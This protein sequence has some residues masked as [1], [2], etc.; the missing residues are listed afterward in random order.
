MTLN[1]RHRNVHRPYL[2]LGA[3]VVALMLGFVTGQSNAGTASATGDLNITVRDFPFASAV[4]P[5]TALVGDQIT[6]RIDYSCGSTTVPCED[7]YISTAVPDDQFIFAP[8]QSDSGNSK[9][10]LTLGGT[11][12]DPITGITMRRII[13]QTAPGTLNC[14]NSPGDTCYLDGETSTAT[15]TLTVRND[16]YD[17]RTNY[18]IEFDA[19]SNI[20]TDGDTP[21]TSPP[22]V[23]INETGNIKEPVFDWEVNKSRVLPPTGGSNPDPALGQPTRYRV[24]LCSDSNVDNYNVNNLYFW[25]DVDDNLTAGDF[26]DLDGGTYYDDAA[27]NPLVPGTLAS[28]PVPA[29]NH[30]IWGPFN[31]AFTDG[32]LNRNLTVVYPDAAPFNSGGYVAENTAGFSAD[33]ASAGNCPTGCASSTV[34]S[35]P[36]DPVTGTPGSGKSILTNPVGVNGTGRFRLDVN[37]NAANTSADDFYI[38]DSMPGPVDH[39]GNAGTPDELPLVITEILPGRWSNR[40]WFDGDVRA[41]IS[42]STEGGNDDCSDEVYTDII[43]ISRGGGN[44][45]TPVPVNPNPNDFRC[46]RIDFEYD[47]DPTG[48]ENFV[49]G[50]PLGFRLNNPYEVLFKFR[51]E[52]PSLAGQTFQNCIAVESSVDGVANPTQNRCAD[53]TVTGSNE[54]VSVQTFKTNNPTDPRPGESVTFTLRVDLVERSSQPL[55]DP[56]IVDALPPTIQIDSSNDNFWD[57]SYTN[58]DLNGPDN[59]AGNA[60]DDIILTK[61]DIIAAG[62]LT[63]TTEDVDMDGVAGGATEP[64][65]V[66]RWDLDGVTLQP[67]AFGTKSIEITINGTVQEFTPAANY[68]NQFHFLIDDP[69]TIDLICENQSLPGD[70]VPDINDFARDGDTT[71]GDVLCF[72]DTTYTVPRT[73]TLDGNKWLR[74]ENDPTN[75]VVAPG[76]PPLTTC[77]DGQ[78]FTENGISAPNYSRFPCVH[79]G[80]ENDTFTYRLYVLNN[81]NVDV[82]NYYLY[83]KLPNFGDTGVSAGQNGTARDSGFRAAMTSNGVQFVKSDR[84]TGA[85][86]S[87]SLMTAADF[88]I[89]YNPSEAPDRPEVGVTTGNS[90]W[91]TDPTTDP[92]NF[93]NGWQDVR[94]FRIRFAGP[95]ATDAVMGPGVRVEFLVEMQIPAIGTFPGNNDVEAGDI[96]WN[97]F[98]HV[99]SYEDG[100]TQTLNPAEPRKVGIYVPEYGSLGNLVFYDNDNDRDYEPGAGE[101]PVPGVRMELYRDINGNGVFD[102]SDQLV[103]VTVTDSD[104]PATVGVNEAGYYLFD[105]LPEGDYFVHIPGSNFAPGAPLYQWNSSTDTAPPIDSFPDNRDHGIDEVDTIANGITSPAIELRFGNEP[106]GAADDDLSFDTAD[107]PNRRGVNGEP[108]DNSDLTVD[109][110]FS[111]QFDWDDNPDSYGTD[112]TDSG[113]EGVGP[114][115][116]ITPALRIGTDVDSEPDGQPSAD[117]S[118]DGPSDDGVSIPPLVAGQTSNVEVS[119]INNTGSPANLVGWIDFDGSGTYEPG[120]SVSVTVPSGGNAPQLITVPVPVPAGATTG[121]THTRWRLTTDPITGANPTGPARDGE[122]EGYPVEIYEAGLSVNKTD[123]QV[124]VVAG[125][126]TTYTITITNNATT[127]RNGTTFTDN[128]PTANPD[129][130]DPA[131]I[132][133]TCAASGGASCIAGDPAGT[134]DSGTNANI[135]ETIDVPVGGTVVYTITATLRANAT[136]T[137]AIV[138]TASVSNPANSPDPVTDSDTNGVIF[139]PPIGTKVGVFNGQD[140]IRWTMEWINTGSAAQPAVITDSLPPEQT[141]AGNLDCV[142]N[143]ITTTDIDGCTYVSGVVTWRGNLGPGPANSILISFDV[144]VS[145]P[146]TYNNMASLST[147]TQTTSASGVVGEGLGPATNPDTSGDDSQGSGGEFDVL[148]SEELDDLVTQLPDTGEGPIW[149]SMIVNAVH[150]GVIAPANGL[151]TMI[152]LTVTLSFD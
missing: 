83:D 106:T 121:A 132:S 98:A 58:E 36:F 70:N 61:A 101:A 124:S 59:I 4:P 14:D 32:C 137:S 5:E 103:D 127:D 69:G 136:G 49:P 18:P 24:Q 38:I 116:R 84:I 147:N 51:D 112:G 133:W 108:D 126:S 22:D 120:E 111:Q 35:H 130:Y 91:V 118:G 71:D 53:V 17:V 47:N 63:I 31:R 114:S 72:T 86:T 78:T 76:E 54:N 8:T 145:G 28:P 30:V 77:Q 7:I 104:D 20:T 25:D 94:S 138:N 117:S 142:G 42:V 41:T 23:E 60:D 105:E 73:A 1:F 19:Y 46:I 96:A 100:G 55:N 89:E 13:L 52:D 50:V 119:V 99:A 66:L 131:T 57:I 129:G 113:G 102:V 141:F 128:I 146:A 11:Y 135:N 67:L 81:S 74:N 95:T 148:S 150:G 56:I 6:F 26:T 107:G 140:R 16:A 143:G 87:T 62:G 43:D 109:F 10:D 125:Q 40:S 21:P 15:V 75:I 12:V 29:T 110:G 97:N 80:E 48:A 90:I 2:A 37:F 123:G 3:V 139:D 79:E 152:D 151:H 134:P 44:G 68:T 85:P 122:V 27:S 115:H 93:P 65:T 34:V 39:D 149:R 88:I 45:T 92:T 33:T 82:F 64:R 9:V 144:L